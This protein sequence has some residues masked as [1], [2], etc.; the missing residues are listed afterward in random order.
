MQEPDSPKANEHDDRITAGGIIKEILETL[1]PAVLLA[2]I[3]S[4]FVAQTTYV[5]GYSMEP[6]LHDQER[7]ITEKMSYHFRAPQRGDIVIIGVGEGQIPL[8]KRVV[9][10]PGETLAI[11]GN[12]VY[13]N[14]L[15][16]SEPYLTNVV[17][18]DFGPVH[19]PVGCFFAMGDNRGASADSRTYGPFHLDQILGRAWMS[20]WPLD[21]AGLLR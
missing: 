11:H 16:L 14:G 2:L 9:G 18:Q 20:Y 7:L 21:E 1:I 15:P 19:V 17:Q 12:Q 3:I 4:H 6:N 13:I 8:I 10:L 5:R